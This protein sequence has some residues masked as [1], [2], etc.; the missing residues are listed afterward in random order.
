MGNVPNIELPSAQGGLRIGQV[1][2]EHRVHYRIVFEEIGTPV[3]QLRT[4]S[5]IFVALRDAVFALKAMFSVKYIH[6][7]VSSS[8][9]L[10]L[11][12]PGGR[13][14]GLLVDLEY[15]KDVTVKSTPHEFRT[16]TRDFMA[17]EVRER[18]YLFRPDPEQEPGEVRRL[19][20]FQH[21]CLHD[22]EST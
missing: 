19:P 7:D 13:A 17:L 9:I 18:S 1:L 6:R 11:R 22:V 4:F 16:G 14:R 8:N 20:P 21:N 10:L 2:E 12:E 5:E 15:A 3:H